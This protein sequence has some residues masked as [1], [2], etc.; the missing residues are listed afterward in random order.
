MPLS[1]RRQARILAFLCQYQR[2][3]LGYTSPLEALLFQE[4]R[5]T[6]KNLSFSRAL[7]TL[8]QEQPTVIDLLIQSHSHKWKQ[9]RLL[10]G[11][12]ALLKVAI[13]ETIAFPQTDSSVIL[14]EALE[15]CRIYVGEGSIKLFNG[16]LHAAATELRVN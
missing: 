15:I 2:Q 12:N 3:K 1:Q 13:A 7:L 9:S 14:N 4:S 10:E 16:I 8:I 5:L 11:F 6:P